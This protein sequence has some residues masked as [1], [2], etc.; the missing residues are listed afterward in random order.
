[1]NTFKKFANAQITQTEQKKVLG[2]TC[3]E[4]PEEPPLNIGNGSGEEPC[5]EFPEEPPLG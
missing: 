4:F 3:C 1:M 5:C 2:G